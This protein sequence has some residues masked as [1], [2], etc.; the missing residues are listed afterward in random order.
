MCNGYD[1]I[2]MNITVIIM[3]NNN[4]LNLEWLSHGTVSRCHIIV[5]NIFK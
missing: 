3:K 5:D 4:C 1:I 2:S